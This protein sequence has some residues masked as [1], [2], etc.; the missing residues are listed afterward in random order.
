M[1]YKE[2][3]YLEHKVILTIPNRYNIFCHTLLTKKSIVL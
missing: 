1:F 3:G 2:L